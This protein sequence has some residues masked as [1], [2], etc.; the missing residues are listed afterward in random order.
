MEHGVYDSYGLEKGIN[1]HNQDG[2]DILSNRSQEELC[3]EN[4]EWS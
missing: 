1:I 4:K 3:T 2:R